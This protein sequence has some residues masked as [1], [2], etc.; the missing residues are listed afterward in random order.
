MKDDFFDEASSVKLHV[1]SSD[2]SSD[3][4]TGARTSYVA[5]V[6]RHL[7]MKIKVIELFDKCIR[8]FGC[9]FLPFI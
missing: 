4:A 6:L 7:A 2:H 3:A 1:M 8:Y 5:C 9:L